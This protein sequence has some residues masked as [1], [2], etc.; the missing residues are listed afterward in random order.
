MRA[1]QRIGALLGGHC[2]DTACLHW[3]LTDGTAYADPLVFLSTPVIRLLPHGA[4]PRVVPQL[5]PASVAATASA[6]PVQG[7]ISSRFGMRLHPITGV[8]KLHDG[9]DIAAPC[10]APIRAPA[11]GVVTRTG[12]HRAYGWRVFVDHGGALVTAYNHLPAVD[13]A[14]GT[15]VAAGQQLGRVGTT[16]LSTGCHLHWMAWRGGALI[17]PLALVS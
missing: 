6:L 2:V 3:G 8:Y 13:V 17:D 10:G 7:S 1:G 16:G 5:S 9:A 4:Q 15:Q 11:A 14:V 12:W